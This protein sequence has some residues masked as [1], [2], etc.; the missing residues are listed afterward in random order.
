MSM[1]LLTMGVPVR[2]H[3]DMTKRSSA[4][5]LKGWSK[6]SHA[7][8]DSF[9]SCAHVRAWRPT[10]EALMHKQAS[11]LQTARK[12]CPDRSLSCC[13]ADVMHTSTWEGSAQASYRL[14]LTCACR[15]GAVWL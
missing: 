6:H 10:F 1:A 3:L 14:Q 9:C 11:C 2:H 4:F 13:K 7:H 12:Q 15:E 8:T 5:P